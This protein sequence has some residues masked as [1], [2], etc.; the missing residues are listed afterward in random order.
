MAFDSPKTTTL[1]FTHRTPI[2]FGISTA[3]RK[4]DAVRKLINV[5]TGMVSGARHGD[6]VVIQPNAAGAAAPAVGVFI[7]SGGSGAV[8]VV[9]GGV[10]I[11]VVWAASDQASA[12]AFVVAFNAS[13]SALVAN[14]VA[15]GQAKKA[16]IVLVSVAAGDEVTV[17]GYKFTARNGGTLKLGEFDMS[18]TDTADAASLAAAINATPGLNQR[19]YAYNNSNAVQLLPLFTS[20]APAGDIINA[21]KGTGFTLTQ[22]AASS[23]CAIYALRPGA[24]GNHVT[25]AASG[26][27]VTLA[28]A[29]SRLVGGV[30][31]NVTR[32]LDSFG[33]GAL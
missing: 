25:L 29:I 7:L 28:N 31:D 22:L 2:D 14:I 3:H 20:A 18:G 8:G 13:V 6:D 5:L 4:R 27:G 32:I 12:D 19:Y 15:A 23:V 26:T 30:G 24:L 11:T 9:V 16:A 33:G 10:T 1:A 17:M 21:T